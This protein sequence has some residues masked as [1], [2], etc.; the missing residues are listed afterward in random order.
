ML[1]SRKYFENVLRNV[2]Q[3]KFSLSVGSSSSGLGGVPL[4][5]EDAD[6]DAPP[7]YLTATGTEHTWEIACNG[8]QFFQ[9]FD[10]SQ[11]RRIH[12]LTARK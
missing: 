3:V 8:P 6:E 12:S 11:A 7:G 2:T 10:L 4:G 1:K 5:V 9:L